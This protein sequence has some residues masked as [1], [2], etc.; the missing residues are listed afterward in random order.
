MDTA[1]LRAVAGDKGGAAR[2]A[3]ATVDQLAQ[4]TDP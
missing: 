1:V 3:R 4:A 2:A